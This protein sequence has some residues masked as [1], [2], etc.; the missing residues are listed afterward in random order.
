MLREFHGYRLADLLADDERGEDASELL[1][2]LNIEAMGTEKEGGET[3]Q[4]R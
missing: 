3:W 1:Q 2:L 4:M